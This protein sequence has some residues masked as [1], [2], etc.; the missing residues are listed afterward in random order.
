MSDSNVNSYHNPEPYIP[1]SLSEIHDFL[2]GLIGGAPTFVDDTG[3]YPNQ[4]ID[5]EF[6]VLLAA[7]DKV[8]EKLDEDRYARLVD[9]AARA[10]ALFEADPDESNGKTLE[11]CK[12]IWEIEEIVQD[13]RKRRV[14]E[15]LKDDE[16]R[17]SGD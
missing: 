17:T 3:F 4:S 13:A 11:G 12:L 5:T 1:E 16:G 6:A 7:F 10:K 15:K 14:E 2:A 8:R 9:L